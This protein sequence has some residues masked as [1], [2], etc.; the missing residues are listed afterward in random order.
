[1]E[2]SIKSA[3]HPETTPASVPDGSPAFIVRPGAAGRWLVVRVAPAGPGSTGTLTVI[4]ECP[5]LHA[6]ETECAHLRLMNTAASGASVERGVFPCDNESLSFVRTQQ[7]QR[8]EIVGRCYFAVPNEHYTP[9]WGTGERAA[10]E[11]LTLL[12][13]AQPVVNPFFDVLKAAVAAAVEPVSRGPSR[14]GAAV[15]FLRAIEDV[16]LGAARYQNH[17]EHLAQKIASSD[18][19]AAKLVA[20][21]IR[22]RAAFV[23]R[24]QAAKVAKRQRKGDAHDNGVTGARGADHV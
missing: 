5:T 20:E 18:H 3:G 11:L 1:M 14:R 16:V 4:R 12:A 17:Q 10:M 8:G 19:W 24:M 9:G 23:A 2:S 21:Q 13:T 22:E 15:G 6:A 7:D